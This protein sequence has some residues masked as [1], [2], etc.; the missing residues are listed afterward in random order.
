MILCPICPM[1]LVL[2]ALCLYSK[3]VGCEADLYLVERFRICGVITPLSHASSYRD[4]YR[5]TVITLLLP[6][7]NRRTKPR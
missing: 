2:R 1:Q 7:I 6:E 5:R 4:A 3:A